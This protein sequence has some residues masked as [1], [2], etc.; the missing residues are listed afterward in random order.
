MSD[1]EQ[2]GIRMAI[3][4]NPNRP[5]HAKLADWAEASAA[6]GDQPIVFALLAIYELLREKLPATSFKRAST[7]GESST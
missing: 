7:P 4:G 3:G 1:R 5:R 6:Q 2:S